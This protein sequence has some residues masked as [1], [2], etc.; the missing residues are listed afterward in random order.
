MRLLSILAMLFVSSFSFSK[1]QSHI[2]S[3]SVIEGSDIALVRIIT[4]EKIECMYTSRVD[5]SGKPYGDTSNLTCN[6]EMRNSQI[7]HPM[8]NQIILPGKKN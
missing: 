4:H 2:Q 1:E 8:T 6:W 3:I 5:H 7:K